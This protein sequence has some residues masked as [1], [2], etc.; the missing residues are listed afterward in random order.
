M[1]TGY[2]LYEFDMFTPAEEIREALEEMRAVKNK[3]PQVH[4]LIQDLEKLLKSAEAFE[5]TETQPA[6]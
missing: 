2:T 1:D 6:A 4:G 3:T 5:Q